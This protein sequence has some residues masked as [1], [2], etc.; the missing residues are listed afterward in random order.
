MKK[1]IISIITA[2]TLSI[3]G[4][5]PLLAESANWDKPVLV[6]GGGLNDAQKE[7]VNSLFKITNLESVDRLTVMGQDAD[8]YLG[9]QDIDTSSLISSVM[10]TKTGEGSGVKVTILTPQ[11]ITMVTETQYAN[12]AITAGA[13]DVNIEV[14]SPTQVTGESA[15]AGVYL[16]LE[17]NGEQI[18]PQS[19]I[20]AQQEL[21]TVN[22]IA[23]EQSTNEE[24]DSTS[25]DLVIAQIKEEL[26]KYKEEHGEIASYE[27]IIAIIR[28]VLNQ[29]KM[30]DVLTDEQISQIAQFAESYQNSPA[31][32][33]K[34]VLEQL[35]SFTDQTMKQLSGQIQNLQESG[36]F[37]RLFKFFSD[38]WSGIMG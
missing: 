22:Q 12:A 2:V 15:L 30:E 32:D 11:N 29:Y 6:Y 8:K 10:V 21:E 36:F 9:R 35:N 14:V 31:I 27:D 16:A 3:C 26:A 17:N 25:F 28:N 34:E 19:T 20:V 18:D 4:A 33:S 23:E 38:L 7:Q 1:I 13:A 37:D 24:F 5:L